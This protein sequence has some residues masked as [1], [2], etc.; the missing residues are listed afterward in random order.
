MPDEHTISEILKAP[1]VTGY[2]HCA[3]NDE[4]LSLRGEGV[5]PLAT[6]INPLVQAAGLLGRCLG[7]DDLRE[8]QLH[9]RQLTALCLPCAS[10]T[11]GVTLDSRAHLNDVAR[12]LHHTLHGG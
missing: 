4:I 6:M 2:L 12:A 7:L 8:L 1:N 10:G 9:G 11:V 3:D 5:E